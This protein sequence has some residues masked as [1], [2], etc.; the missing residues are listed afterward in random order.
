VTRNPELFKLDAIHSAALP[1]D[2]AAAAAVPLWTDD[3]ASLWRI[4]K[5]H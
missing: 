5:L 1:P 3:Y 2:E 4:L